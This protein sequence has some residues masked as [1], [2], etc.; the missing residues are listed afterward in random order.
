MSSSNREKQRLL[1]LRAEK[2]LELVGISS[3][4][5]EQAQNLPHGHQQALGI[6]I[7]LAANPKLLLL[8]EP[9]TGMNPEETMMM[10]QRIRKIAADGISIMIIEHDMK[11]IMNLCGRIIA[12]NYGR[13]IAEGTPDEI[14]ENPEVI[15]AYLGTTDVSA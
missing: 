11:V 13:K 1:N 6:A 3:Q 7:A 2:I 4:R 12:L 10:M 5:H 9:A 15:Q 14:R 8:D